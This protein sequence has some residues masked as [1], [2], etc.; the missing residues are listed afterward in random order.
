MVVTVELAAKSLTITSIPRDSRVYIKGHGLSKINAAHAYGGHRLTAA[1]VSD[2]FGI[3]IDR[4]VVIDSASLRKIC[5]LVGPLE[6]VVE[7]RMNY[8]DRAGRLRIN[9]VPGRQLLSPA[10][11]EQYVRFRNDA[12]SD[13]GRIQRQQW[14]IRQAFS[15]VCSPSFLWKLP[16]LIPIA[17]ESIRTDLSLADMFRITLLAQEIKQREIVTASLPGHPASIGGISYWVLDAASTKAIFKRIY[18]SELP[19]SASSCAERLR[20]AIE[21]AAGSEQDAL[22]L[23]HSLIQLGH[24][25][26]LKQTVRK[27]DCMHEQILLSSVLVSRTTLNHMR[28][29]IPAIASWPEVIGSQRPNTDV[30]FVISRRRT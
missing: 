19:D 3:P 20:I 11:V 27:G 24:D 13:I 14:F 26:K 15:K 9:L 21:Y 1:T 7:K 30:I 17:R 5:E 25:V 2:A 22:G 29:A 8:I 10:Q 16:R 12:D 6:V 18:A 23:E 4:Y 28:R